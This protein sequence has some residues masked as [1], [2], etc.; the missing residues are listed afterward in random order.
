MKNSKIQ[1][2]EEYYRNRLFKRYFSS[3][4][5][6]NA[7]KSKEKW[8]W[9]ID[10]THHSFGEYFSGFDSKAKI[11]DAGCG[12][13]YLEY[14]LLKEGFTNIHAVDISRE[15]LVMAKHNLNYYE[16]E[17]KD[18]VNFY[19]EDITKFLKS[20]DKFDIICL[21]DVIEHLSKN[22]A[23]KLIELSY[24]K[25]NKNGLIIIRVPNMEHPFLS[26]YNFYQDFTHESAFTRSS[27][28]QCLLASGF[29]GLDV[30]F[31]KWLPYKPR[32]ITDYIKNAAI[33]IYN[34]FISFIIRVPSDSICPNIIGVGK[35]S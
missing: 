33:P 26:S 22:N 18:K 11:L 9:T 23:F 20:S 15:Q 16:T 2:N 6:S 24:K 8:Q 27:L 5:E 32:K 14:Y 13:G 12:T 1:N 7:P 30:K 29:K 28:S 3:H 19:L 21:I 10:L 31:E 35:K 25:L 34:S 17:F 4:F